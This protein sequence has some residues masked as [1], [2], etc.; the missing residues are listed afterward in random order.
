LAQATHLKASSYY[1]HVFVT[2]H[3]QGRCGCHGAKALF[4]HRHPIV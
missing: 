1:I 4:S 2:A 3:G